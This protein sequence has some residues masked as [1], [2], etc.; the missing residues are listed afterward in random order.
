[1]QANA[2]NLPGPASPRAQLPS[3]PDTLGHDGPPALPL[4]PG[5]GLRKCRLTGLW[6]ASP[7]PRDLHFAE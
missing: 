1:M 6:L 4:P 7:V 5:M 3:W 2:G